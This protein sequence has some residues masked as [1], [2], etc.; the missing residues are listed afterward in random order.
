MLPEEIDALLASK[1]LETY[2][3]LQIL[4]WLYQK[5]A[6]S[7]A[8]MTNLPGRL[9]EQL[10]GE[11]RITDLKPLE[12]KSSRRDQ[13]KKFL[14]ELE[15][16]AAVETVLMPERGRGTV[17]VSTQVGCAFGCRFCASGEG[18]LVRDLTAGEIVDQVRRARFDSDAVRLTNVVLMG[19]GEPLANYGVSARAV[20][21]FQHK[22]CF[23]I[24]KR[25]ITISTAGYVPGIQRLA[26]DDLEVRLAISLHA[27]DDKTRNRLMPIN[28]KYPIK[29]LL[30]ACKPLA[31]NPQTPLTIEYMLI[32]GVND[33][34][35]QARELARMANS[36]SAKVNLLYYNPALS[37]KF[38]APPHEQ[39][40]RFQATLKEAGVLAL[41]RRSRGQDIQGACG[42][43]RASRRPASRR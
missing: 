25:R 6:R 16:G 41:I 15:D 5:D 29:K 12:V 27:T 24:G 42:Q 39:A 21:I 7:F 37:K 43:L 36:L 9:R 28:K 34:L 17:C 30:E 32:E 26:E 19:M 33:S 20:R 31:G 3:S 1:G 2:R 14:F 4:E 8:E 35:R 40:L 11:C 38:V 10:S 18:G 22:R 23:G 13:T